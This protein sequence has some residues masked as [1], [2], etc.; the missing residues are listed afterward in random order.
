RD[1]QSLARKVGLLDLA[2]QLGNLSQACREIGLSRDSYYRIK[3]L[4]ETAGEAALQARSKRHPLL[5]NRVLPEIEAAVVELAIEEPTWGQVQVAHELRKRGLTISPAG[6]RSVWLR[7]ELETTAKRLRALETKV[8]GGGT[9][10]T[11]AQMAALE[12]LRIDK[13]ANG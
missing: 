8:A 4:Y 3:R 12:N 5:A 9:V 6:V 10:L 2:S 11:R 1:Q 13:E 7:R